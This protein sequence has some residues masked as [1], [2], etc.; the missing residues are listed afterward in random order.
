MAF[1]ARDCA[2]FDL[3]VSLASYCTFLSYSVLVLIA[4]LNLDLSQ[5]V[6]I[7]PHFKTCV[8]IA[9]PPSHEALWLSLCT[10]ASNNSPVL[11]TASDDSTT[12]VYTACW[13]SD[14]PL[15]S[16]SSSIAVLIERRVQRQEV[17]FYMYLLCTINE[18]SV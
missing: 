8:D 1:S 5:G 9:R 7:R 16:R 2:L 6:A 14:Q 13:W 17:G 11:R 12:R 18:Y 10:C 15:W 4:W 3:M